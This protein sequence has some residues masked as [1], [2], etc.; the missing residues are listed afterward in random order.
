VAY[1]DENKDEEESGNQGGG[2]Q[3]GPE[4]GT[5]A[6]GSQAP[7]SAAGPGSPG[8]QA[9]APKKDSFVNI[10][11]YIN[12]N[13][14]QSEKLATQ[15]TDSV[16]QKANAADSALNSA[17]N[18]FN[19][20]AD[21]QKVT[22]DPSLFG[23][24]SQDARA[25]TKDPSKASQFGSY[26]NAGY[27]GP[28]QIE[29]ID[30]G[31]TWTG[32]QNAISSAKAAK[33]ETGTEAG[34]MQ[35]IKDVSNNP[36]QSQ[37]GL[38][39]D[40]LLLQSN[41]NS[42]EMLQGAGSNLNDIDQRASAA[43][44]NAKAYAQSVANN[45]AA[46]KQQASQAVNSGYNNIYGADPGADGKYGTADDKN[47]NLS[48]SLL[49]RVSSTQASQNQA[50]KDLQSRLQTGRMTAAD[51]KLLGISPEETLYGAKPSQF[52]SA[53]ANAN[54]QNIAGQ[55]DYD[56]L[57]ALQSLAGQAGP[58]F[59]NPTT[60]KSLMGTASAGYNANA[61]G[62]QSKITQQKQDYTNKFNDLVKAD[63][64]QSGYTDDGVKMFTDWLLNGNDPGGFAPSAL[65]DFAN[66][67]VGQKVI[68][69]S[70]QYGYQVPTKLVKG[71][72]GPQITGGL[73][74]PMQMPLSV[75]R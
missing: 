27:S 9:A 33:N 12:A 17:S 40:N 25:V 58:G 66:S 3:V 2:V 65:N 34:R 48:D 28:Q 64:G 37:G 21:A 57:S 41:P 49:G 56:K 13:K 60:D 38:V 45:N 70:N 68:Q 55:D 73:A 4:S 5:V 14:P 71:T 62:L 35:L 7:A 24:V 59:L 75:K 42:A 47:L 8:T 39:F 32:L 1:Y 50:Y 63:G 26:L 69:L 18:S 23:A 29:D 15:V 54:I 43:D 51:Y 74:T 30:Q 61:P 52:V 67:A 20:A 16:N 44:A 36:R 22:A 19:Q 46:V 11:D 31:N 6:Q 72:V 53:N 10:S